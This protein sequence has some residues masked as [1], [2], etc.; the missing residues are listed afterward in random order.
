MSTVRA[1]VSIQQFRCVSPGVHRRSP[2]AG[3][4]AASLEAQSDT[5]PCGQAVL[6]ALLEVA[7][8]GWSIVV[9][10]AAKPRLLALHDPAACEC[11]AAIAFAPDLEIRAAIDDVVRLRLDDRI[12]ALDL[13]AVIRG[14]T[15]RAAGLAIE[16]GLEAFARR[17]RGIDLGLRVATARR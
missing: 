5:P 9:D 6:A 1:A 15:A 4:T 16:R 3:N 10:D 7:A 8:G 14:A 13:D 11:R 17:P 12:A 2:I